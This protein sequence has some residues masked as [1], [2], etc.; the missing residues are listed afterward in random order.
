MHVEN[1]VCFVGFTCMICR[2]YQC[3][4]SLQSRWKRTWRTGGWEQVIIENGIYF[5][6]GGTKGGQGSTP[7]PFP[8]FEWSQAEKKQ[9]KFFINS[10]TKFCERPYMLMVHLGTLGNERSWFID[11]FATLV[12]ISGNLLVSCNLFLLY[13][14]R[15]ILTFLGPL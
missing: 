10:Q 8:R 1:Y 9:Q 13:I 6:S 5:V 3:G 14:R 2:L 15:W 11:W 4:R 7:P 12:T